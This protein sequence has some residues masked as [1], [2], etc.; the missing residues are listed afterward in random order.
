MT[1]TKK[2]AFTR[3]ELQVQ[4]HSRTFINKYNSLPASTSILCRS[5]MANNNTTWSDK[6]TCTDYV[7]FDSC[8]D[9]F[10]RF[11]QSKNVCFC[12]DVKLKVFKKDDNKDFQL[13]QTP[14]IGEATFNQFMWLRDQLVIAA[15]NFDREENLSSVL[16][17][18]KSKDMDEQLKLAHN[19]VDLVD[20]ENR[21]NGVILLR[22]IV[23]KPKRSYAQV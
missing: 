23:Y 20:R 4:N 15:K 19:V 5:T 8:Q 6:L 11:S 1:M 13:V 3:Y 22:Y 10:R 7:N 9:R 14:S 12:L 16:I 17:P 18:K 2:D 21:K